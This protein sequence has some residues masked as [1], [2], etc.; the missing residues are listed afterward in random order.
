MLPL[1]LLV[2]TLAH[3]D[4][5]GPAA[6]SSS[7][8]SHRWQLQARSPD[9]QLSFHYGLLQPLLLKG[10]NAAVDLRLGRFVATYSHGQGLDL[11]SVSGTRT[12]AEEKAGLRVTVPY[13]TGGGVGVTLIDELYVLADFKA[14]RYELF[15]GRETNRYTTVTVGA[16]VGWRFFIWKGLHVTPVLRYWPNVWDSASKKG[17]TVATRDGGELLHKPLAQGVGGFFANVLVGWAFN[18]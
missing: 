12:G 1:T 4:E 15:A 11:T 7:F 5:H 2:P 18:L 8:P 3:A 17:V 13:T 9:A 14:H 6:P 10:F 16:E